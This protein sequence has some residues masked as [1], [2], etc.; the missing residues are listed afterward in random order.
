MV[1]NKSG[2][3]LWLTVVA[4]IAAVLVIASV[5]INL[6]AENGADLRP[7]DTPEGAVQRYL[8]ALVDDDITAAY[9]Y[10]SEP[11]KTDCTLQYFAQMT[12]Y[13]RERS[14]TARLSTTLDLSGIKQVNVEIS[15][16]DDG[17]FFGNGYSYTVSFTLAE[18][19][20]QW[21]FT[22]PPWP[23]SWCPPIDE[24]RL[25]QPGAKLPAEPVTPTPAT[26]GGA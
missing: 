14:F 23:M 26:A 18:E 19:D 9:E 20:G 15:D 3:A 1:W 10:M 12:E 24:Q 25:S 4:V 7:E 8:R 17:P 6:V 13:Q 11:V 5:V 16:S 22:E 2:P 21:L